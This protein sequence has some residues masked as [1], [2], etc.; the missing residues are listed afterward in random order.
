MHAWMDA[1]S[2]EEECARVARALLDLGCAAR[3]DASSGPGILVAGADLDL[4]CDRAR[5]LSAGGRDRLLVIAALPASTTT[6]ATWRLLGAGASDVLAWRG[7]AASPPD[8]QARLSR[9]AEIDQ[10]LDSPLVRDHLIGD[11]GAW[12]SAV[13]QLIEVARF[14][15]SSLLVLGETGTGKELAA[16]LFHA[17]DA[18]RDKKSL[19]ILDCSTLVP[20]LAGSEFFGHER[21]AYTGAVGPREGA[22]ELAHGGTLFLDEVG[23]LPLPLQAQ[24]LRVIQERTFKR[25]GGNTWQQTDFRLICATNR[26][27]AAEVASGR[28]RG[29]LYHRIASWVCRLPPLRERQADILPLARHFLGT[30]R[31]G[32]PP[33]ELDAAVR[34]LL[35][36]R[37]YPGNVRELRQLVL[38]IAERHAG[39]GPLT[40]GDVPPAD[41]PAEAEAPPSPPGL[42][43]AIRRALASG[44]GLK[45]IGREATESAIRLVVEEEGGNL[46]R[47]AQRLGVT[48]RALQL[49]RRSGAVNRG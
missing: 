11:S 4:A 42:E 10:V 1:A 21:G 19:V 49:R 13:R 8:I 15:P 41:R 16:R 18:R 48:D 39:D 32:G 40:A 7:E 34:D 31:A 17:L 47:A 45:D 26:D 28:F 3:T 36:R 38:R 14:T 37:T 5:Q 22:F 20:E 29:D 24:L 43:D 35:V 46:Q 33:L 9:W 30:A 12:T 25:V 44:A 2:D 23:E 6:A 27:L